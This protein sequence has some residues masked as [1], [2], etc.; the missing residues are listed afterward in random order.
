MSNK[1]ITLD[2]L[3]EF[4]QQLEQHGTGGTGLSNE[5]KDA[6]LACFEHVAWTN[7]SGQLYYDTLYNL[8]YPP[9]PL[10]SISAVYTQSGVVYDTQALDSL[11]SDLVVTGHYEDGSRAT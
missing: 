7:N 10:L 3:A 6:L 4:K 9:V 11:K 8:L 5:I 2:N 1:I